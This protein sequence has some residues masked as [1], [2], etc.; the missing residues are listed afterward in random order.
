MWEVDVGVTADGEL[1]IIHDSSLERTSNS[2]DLFPDRHPWRVRDFTLEEMRCLDFGSW[3]N[4]TDPFGLI[5][6]G[7]VSAAERE[8]YIGEPVPTLREALQF[9]LDHDWRV[10][11]EIKD[12]TGTAGDAVVVEGVVD[13]IE[14]LDAEERAL[15]SSFNQS[16]LERVRELNTRIAT[17]IL[18][19]WK[20]PDP[21][22]LLRRL[23]ANAYHPKIT[24][25]S[26]DEISRLEAQG[27]C[28][29]TWVVNDGSTALRLI[30][31]GVSGIFTDFPQML[32][33]VLGA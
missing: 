28:V 27:F 30:E 2:R 33:R 32:H 16:H 31:A 15:I 13:L 5:A 12:L 9:T 10:N 1:I 14:R 29:H 3:F 18:V 20:L 23:R 25:I 21:V 24:A 19:S 22:M 6:C 26:L 17:G 7:E 11:V 8:S 4:R